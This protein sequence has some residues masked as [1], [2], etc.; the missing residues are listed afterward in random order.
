MKITI[1]VKT[2]AKKEEIEFDKERNLYKVSIK[3]LPEK[4]KANQ[5]IKKLFKNK[6]KKDIEIISGHTNKK[7]LIKVS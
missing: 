7:K 2:N 5:A 4:G 1:L 6:W 3:A